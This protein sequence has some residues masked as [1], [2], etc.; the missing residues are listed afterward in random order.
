MQATLRPIASRGPEVACLAVTILL[1]LVCAAT[2]AASSHTRPAGKESVVPA[3]LIQLHALI[4]RSFQRCESG[5]LKPA[6]SRRVKTYVA[7]SALARSEGYYGADQLVLL[8][9]RLFEART[10]I[11]F[12]PFTDAPEIRKDGRAILSARWISRGS[13]SSRHEMRFTFVMARERDGWRIREI[14]DLK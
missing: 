14:R 5:L 9:K 3:P 1:S 8:F 12:A 10:T 11:R 13:G 2:P 6:F 4:E 7:S